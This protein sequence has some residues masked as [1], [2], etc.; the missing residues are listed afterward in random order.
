MGAGTAQIPTSVR[1]AHGALGRTRQMRRF[2]GTRTLHAD[3]L[4][5]AATSPRTAPW[6]RPNSRGL[7]HHALATVG[8]PRPRVV[9]RL[10]DSV[11]EDAEDDRS[12]DGCRDGDR[13]RGDVARDA[14]AASDDGPEAR[15][16]CR[17]HPASLCVSL[18]GCSPA[19]MGARHH[20]HVSRGRRGWR[21][22]RRGIG[23]H[24]VPPCRRLVRGG[25]PRTRTAWRPGRVP[26]RVVR[27][28]ER[29]GACGR[30]A[31]RVGSAHGSEPPPIH[32][33]QTLPAATKSAAAGE[34]MK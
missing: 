34:G 10:A 5:Q 31:S 15:A 1:C 33:A 18:E 29:G 25:D 8:A 6:T 22:G 28:R 9:H 23:R 3:I 21:S 20:P 17:A 24:V 14:Q 19:A 4:L 2:V 11:P 7:Q 32:D 13:R 16:S 26:T 12:D 30:S 27:A